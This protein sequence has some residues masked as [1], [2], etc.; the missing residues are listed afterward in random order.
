[1][2]TFNRPRSTHQTLTANSVDTVTLT[3]PSA[4]QAAGAPFTVVGGVNTYYYSKVE[5]LNRD[6]AV[7]LY[8]T[9]DGSTPGVGSDSTFAVLPGQGLVV[10]IAPAQVVKVIAAGAIGYSVTG[11]I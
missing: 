7:T 4:D 9:V 5:V 1:M 8:F 10:A 2:A 11:V 3:V 6:S